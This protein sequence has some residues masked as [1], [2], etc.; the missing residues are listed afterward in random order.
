MCDSRVTKEM[1]K[2][3]TDLRGRKR[4]AGEKAEWINWRREGGK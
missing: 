4:A 2:R 1:H 3:A